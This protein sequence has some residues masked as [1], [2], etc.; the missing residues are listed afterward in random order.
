MLCGQIQ[1]AKGLGLID[2]VLAILPWP[3]HKDLNLGDGSSCRNDNGNIGMICSLSIPIVT[4]CALILLII[5]V[6][7]LDMVL[8]WLPF[9]IFCFPIPGL[10]G[11]KKAPA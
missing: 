2:L 4:I 7:L 3:L 6:S 5:I 10:S 1:R 8:R 11:K 9:F